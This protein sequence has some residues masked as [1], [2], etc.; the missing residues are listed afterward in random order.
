[1]FQVGLLHN[2]NSI[3]DADNNPNSRK[4]DCPASDGEKVDISSNRQ[5]A[6]LAN[7]YAPIRNDGKSTVVRYNCSH[8]KLVLLILTIFCVL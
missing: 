5:R 2:A 4:R 7:G 6:R 1:V 3:M 8:G